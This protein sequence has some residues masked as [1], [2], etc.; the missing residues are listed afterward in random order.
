MT[1]ET[2]VVG[3][4][5][6]S[7]YHLSGL[8]QCP[9]TNLVAICDLDESRAREKAT[10]YDI[11]AYADFEGMLARESLDWIHLCTPVGTHLELARMA[12][13]DGIPVLIEKP[14]TESVAEAE[15]LER[16]AEEYDA[17]VSVVHN[18][19]FSPAMRKARRLIE[20]GAIG[21]LRSV[22]LLYAG[23]TYP[24]DVRRGAWAFELPGGEFEEGLPH[25]IY[26]VLNLGGYPSSPDAIQA[27]TSLAD[28]YAQ[29]FEYDSVQFQYTTDDGVLCS[30]TVL[31][32]DVPHKVIQVHG[33]DGSIEI[34]VVSQSVTVLDRDYQASPK[35][36][37]LANVDHVLGRLR[38]TAE[39]LVAVARRS[40][41][42]DWDSVRNL[43][44]HSYQFGEEVR[45]IQRGE[46]TA[47]PVAEGTWTLRVM[48]TIRATTA[49]DAEGQAV[50]LST[51]G[52]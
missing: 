28:E 47:V 22:D 7:D 19:N 44:S 27:S 43:D 17:T 34:D 38:G 4:G 2:A 51:D 45:A 21:E 23:E 18:H 26:M 12:I 36:R 29:G 25:P 13:E 8:E 46:P 48:E 11:N 3:G 37:A 33:D 40:I 6:V 42:D 24:D 41:D 16:L 39:N 31:A 15:E 9:D 10:E 14:V 20:D 30:G 32:S 52:T 35:A 1:L 50:P 49:D 5:V